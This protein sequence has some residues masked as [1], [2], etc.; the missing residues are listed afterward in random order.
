MTIFHLANRQ[1]P[2]TQSQHNSFMQ[3]VRALGAVSVRSSWQ[4][5]GIGKIKTPLE[6]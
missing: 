5:I 4:V 2:Y 1:D 3:Q 6:Y